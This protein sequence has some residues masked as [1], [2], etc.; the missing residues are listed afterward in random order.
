LVF[1]G[2]FG[3]ND[4][5]QMVRKCNL[6]LISK[7]RFDS[8]LYLP[9]EGEY[10]GRGR[11]RKYGEKLNYKTIAKQYL[12]STNVEGN[13]RTSTYQ[14]EIWHKLFPELLNVV[15]I[16]K[17]NLK[18]NKTR[19]VILFSS[20]LELAYDKLITYYKLRFQIEF[21]FRDAKQHWGLE[22]FMNVSKNAVY[23]AANLAMFMVNLSSALLKQQNPNGLFGSSVNDLKSWFR[24]RKYV[25]NT[26]K[27]YEE[28]ADPIFIERTIHQVSSLGRINPS[29]CQI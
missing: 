8:A 28:N 22:D 24:A 23:N 19:R 4:A 1:D 27:L 15:I 10:C 7:L 5:L 11:R 21:N 12:K 3:N 6:H 25:L 29:V 17:T 2:A 20:D 13:I 18:T 26:L 9:Y 16:I 14:I